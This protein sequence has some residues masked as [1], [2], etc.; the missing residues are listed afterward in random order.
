M[1]QPLPK[2]SDRHCAYCLKLI[3]T[4]SVKFSQKCNR[5]AYCS[6]NC[7]KIDWEDKGGQG[8][9]NWCDLVCGEE[10]IDWEVKESPGKGLGVFAK[11]LIRY[12]IFVE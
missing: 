4:G 12:S 10:D 7:R 8:H 11:C 6:D 1:S 9:Q 3:K 5:R 2:E